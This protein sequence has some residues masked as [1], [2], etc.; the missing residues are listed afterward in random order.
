MLVVLTNFTFFMI[1]EIF[2]NFVYAFI[3][4]MINS[5]TLIDLWFKLKNDLIK[6]V[7]S[8]GLFVDSFGLF[9]LFDNFISFISFKVTS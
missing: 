4:L 7:D 9:D 8:F 1:L 2:F 6:E 3:S 5:L